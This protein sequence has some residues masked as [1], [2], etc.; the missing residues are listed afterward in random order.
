M[1]DTRTKTCGTDV[2]RT[3]FFTI[4]SSHAGPPLLLTLIRV[5]IM[6][7]AYPMPTRDPHLAHTLSS[8]LYHTTCNMLASLSCLILVE[9][10]YQEW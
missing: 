1:T 8:H 2:Y 3:G 4:S 6:D 9:A 7:H 10:T 5:V